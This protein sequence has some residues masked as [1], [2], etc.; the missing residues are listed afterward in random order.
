[1]DTNSKKPF[2]PS[3]TPTSEASVAPMVDSF[4]G[5]ISRKLEEKEL[6]ESQS[7]QASTERYHLIM[8]ALTFIRKALQEA[9]K[10]RLGERFSLKTDISDAEGWPK[11]TLRLFDRL[12]PEWRELTVE[13][14]ASD[15]QE[16]GLIQMETH[17]GIK[18]LSFSITESDAM[19]RLPIHLKKALRSFLDE[20]ESYV[21]DPKKPE[22]LLSVQTK[23]IETTEKTST[24]NPL[25]TT[26]VFES[27]LPTGSD[28]K[29]ATMIGAPL[30]VDIFSKN[31]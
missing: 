4:A 9:A 18:L 20:I 13:A 5:R 17:A 25:S 29:E 19:Q 3:K 30:S 26:N 8:Q 1:M 31:E 6:A 21:L 11:I 28:S 27:D 2:F 16:N 22:E 12:A 10:I 7:A 23:K 15:R 14:H 24:F